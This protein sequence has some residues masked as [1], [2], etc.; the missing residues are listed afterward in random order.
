MVSCM[1]ET[2]K[3]VHNGNLTIF[4][5]N[6]L[7]ATAY[8]PKANLNTFLIPK[9]TKGLNPLLVICAPSPKCES[10]HPSVRIYE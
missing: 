5:H 6:T 10:Q 7:P 1:K 3:K 8:W 2:L 4:C 9:H